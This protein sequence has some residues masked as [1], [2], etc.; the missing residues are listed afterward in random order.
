MEIQKNTAEAIVEESTFDLVSPL[1]NK[2]EIIF[3]EDQRID[4]SIEKI[5]PDSPSDIHSP[6]RVLATVEILKAMQG[7][8]SITPY[9]TPYESQFA[10]GNVNLLVEQSNSKVNDLIKLRFNDLI[11]KINLAT[12]ASCIEDEIRN[13]IEVFATILNSQEGAELISKKG[14]DLS[15]FGDLKNP[16]FLI[17]LMLFES[18]NGLNSSKRKSV[19]DY[20]VGS[21][22]CLSENA[23]FELLSNAGQLEENG[24]SKTEDVGLLSDYLGRILVSHILNEQGGVET[25]RFSKNS[26]KTEIV[27]DLL[28]YNF[29]KIKDS[30]CVFYTP[31]VLFEELEANLKAVLNAIFD[32]S[33][34]E[35]VA[36]LH[37][38]VSAKEITEKLK[39]KYNNSDM[40]IST[41][42]AG[43]FD[44]FLRT[45]LKDLNPN[46]IRAGIS[47]ILKCYK[48]DLDNHKRIEKSDTNT[49]TNIIQKSLKMVRIIMIS[50]LRV[51]R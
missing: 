13:Y 10:S 28:R 51:K 23:I 1:T 26:E 22:T 11:E 34:K 27:N 15:D 50:N 37:L 19:I 38:I 2:G 29:S 49:N 36:I 33:K 43:D 3:D 46:K 45:M 12:D 32:Y 18:K 16:A 40:I 48:Q 20:I 7:F 44:S 8:T 5:D 4:L 21:E 17:S 9:E 24:Y 42:G 6:N 30:D 47:K 35:Y 41:P 31:D 25:I 39:I 14:Y